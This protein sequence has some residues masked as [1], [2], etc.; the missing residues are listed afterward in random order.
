MKTPEEMRDEMDAEKSRDW[1]AEGS[2]G[3]QTVVE[4]GRRLQADALEAAAQLCERL[5]DEEAI[6]TSPV[7]VE[8][9]R[10]LKP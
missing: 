10:K 6:R 8:S 9:I 4:F 3:W 7:V 2:R 5:E 1:E